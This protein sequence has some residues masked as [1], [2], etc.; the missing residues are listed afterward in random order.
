MLFP[1]LLCLSVLCS[2]DGPFHCY[3]HFSF[4][5]TVIIYLP[6]VALLS[7]LFCATLNDFLN[8]KNDLKINFIFRVA[9]TENT[10]LFLFNPLDNI[11]YDPLDNIT[12]LFKCACK[13]REREFLERGK[14]Q[15]KETMPYI[16][17]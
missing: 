10:H 12:D 3:Y 8:I 7:I 13:E 11:S 6:G 4:V 2:R 15:R 14:I 9:L 16:I 1:S 5:I 17:S